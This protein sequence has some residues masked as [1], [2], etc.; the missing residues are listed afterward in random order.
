[1]YVLLRRSFIGLNPIIDRYDFLSTINNKA[2]EYL[3]AGL[4]IISCPKKGVLF[5]LIRN[6]K[7]G[8]S[9]EYGNSEELAQILI[10]L[11]NNPEVR[12]EMSFNAE[13][14]FK[15][16]FDANIVYKEMMKHLENI[17]LEYKA[18]LFNNRTENIK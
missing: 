12:S 6:E 13:I 11:L 15:N 1:M 9:F 5:E 14:L 17:V 18:K 16:K 3:S 10:Y 2:I 7:C 4:P 8:M